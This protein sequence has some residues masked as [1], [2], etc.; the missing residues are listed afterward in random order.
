MTKI[1]LKKT[2]D[3]YKAKNHVLQI[4]T[5]PSTQYIMIDGEG[6]PNTAD[7]YTNAI[8]ALFPIAY[9]IKFASKIE[10]KRDFVVMPL[11]GLWWADDMSA[12]TSGRDKSKW[13]W[14]LMI[15]Q[16]DWI[17]KDM[18]MKAV[19]DL[20]DKNAPKSLGNVRFETL[21]ERTCVQTLHVGSFDDEAE[22]LAEMHNIFIPANNLKMI[23]KHHEIYFSDVRKVAPA[24]WR[25]ILRQPVESN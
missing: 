19:R 24:K 5:I 16:P 22:I 14:T 4:V 21:H 11:E 7:E 23:G 15:M 6:D 17:T 2:L 13:K 8:Q 9:K 20:A 25:T 18:F 10:L 12:F 3:S 1:D